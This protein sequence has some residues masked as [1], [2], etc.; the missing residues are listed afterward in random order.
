MIALAVPSRGLIF[1]QVSEALE[2]ECS[3]HD[4]R[5]YY[6]YDKAIPGAH[7]SLVEQIISDEKV[8]GKF[9]HIWF[10]EEDTVPPVDSL[11][12][13]LAA[14][15]GISF[16]DYGVSGWSCS[17]R[18]GNEIL[19]CGLGCTLIKREVF[20]AVAYPW[21][22]SDK[23]LRLNDWKWVENPSKYGGQD[24]WF[25]RQAVEK[26]YTIKEVEGECVHLQLEV[27]G[28]AGMN[29]GLHII[30]EKEK[31]MK[32]QFIRKVGE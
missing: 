9:T 31:I 22:R 18:Q 32:Q 6:S 16:I 10:V 13:L 5:A 23:T 28:Q 29:N 7:N 8:Y 19:W 17:A 4:V 27:L 3:F 30:K 15:S 21:F 25:C 26:G 11:S 2:R 24:I 12:D 1:T 14:D 20:D